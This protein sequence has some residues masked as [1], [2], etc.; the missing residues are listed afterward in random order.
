MGPVPGAGKLATVGGTRGGRGPDPDAGMVTTGML[1]MGP[2]G[3]SGEMT[4]V[5]EGGIPPIGWC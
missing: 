4:L 2:D 5:G 3:G 1:G